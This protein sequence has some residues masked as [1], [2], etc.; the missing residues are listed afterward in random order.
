MAN[1]LV[2]QNPKISCGRGIKIV[3]R[4]DQRNDK[5]GYEKRA[6]RMA[7]GGLRL[8][9]YSANRNPDR[10]SLRIHE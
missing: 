5:G 10:F 3:V 6:C 1:I 2:P 4:T 8:G 9:L 7:L